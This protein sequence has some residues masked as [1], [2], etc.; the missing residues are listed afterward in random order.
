MKVDR[1]NHFLFC[2]VFEL[3][4]AH[5][6]GRLAMLREDEVNALLDELPFPLALAAHKY[7]SEGRQKH[8]PTV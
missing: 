8:E 7:I 3:M 5:G 6:G 4:S 1:H 2:A